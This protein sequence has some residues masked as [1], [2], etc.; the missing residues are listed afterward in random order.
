MPEASSTRVMDIE[1]SPLDEVWPGGDVISISLE[2]DSA[3]VGRPIGKKD[4]ASQN[5]YILK[6]RKCI[7]HCSIQAICMTQITE[8]VKEIDYQWTEGLSTGVKRD[9]MLLKVSFFKI[10]DRAVFEPQN[11]NEITW[12][13]RGKLWNPSVS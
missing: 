2:F 3:S 5:E 13:E 11:L 7:W 4:S 9:G 8:A 12:E 10:H 1:S 6:Q